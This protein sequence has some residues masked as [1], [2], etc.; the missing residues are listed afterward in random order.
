MHHK[1]VLQFMIRAQCSAPSNS[2]KAINNQRNMQ[3][4]PGQWNQPVGEER[5]RCNNITVFLVEAR[6]TGLKYN[7]SSQVYGQHVLFLYL[8]VCV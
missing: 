4:S 5:D 6:K 8:G 7:S 1:S 2:Q 3:I